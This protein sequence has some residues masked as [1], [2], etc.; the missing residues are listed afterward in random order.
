MDAGGRLLTVTFQLLG[1]VQAARDGHLLDLGHARQRCVLATLLVDAN[2]TLPADVVIERVWDDDPPRHARNALSGYVSRLRALLAGQ[3]AIVHRHGGYLLR[4][5]PELVDLHRFRRLVDTA[6]QA[7]DGASSLDEALGLWRGQ[8]FAGIDSRWLSATRTALAEERLAAELDRNDLILARGGYATVLATLSRRAV[9]FPFDERVAGQ[10]MR[11]LYAGGRQAEALRHY[12]RLRHRLATELGIDP[13]TPLQQVYQR[14]LA[15]EPQ[16][17]QPPGPAAGSRPPRQLPAAPRT[18]AGRVLE[19]GELDLLPAESAD[20]PAVMTIWGPAGVGKTALVVHWAHRVADSFPDGQLYVDLR[21]FDV[22][23][24]VMSAAEALRGF[25]NAMG[26][27]AQRMPVGQSAQAALYRS[28]L[29][30][31]RVL[32]VLDNARDAEQVRPLLPGSPGCVA[33]VT[34]RRVLSGLIATDGARPMT[35]GL[36]TELEARALLEGRLGRHRLAP[37]R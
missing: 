18:F 4:V 29:A 28:M 7:A 32:I 6:R 1:E 21:G 2:R 36:F 10:L 35:L 37:S 15:T 13:G 26:V 30:G 8:A 20:G 34:S 27:H 22:S 19:I 5:D 16:P 24:S 17:P 11:A 31:R 14:I 3:P 23:G 25:L 33:V 9:E 12:H